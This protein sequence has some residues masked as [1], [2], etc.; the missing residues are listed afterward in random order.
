MVGKA[1][2]TLANFAGSGFG[3]VGGVVATQD[4]REFVDAVLFFFEDVFE[5]DF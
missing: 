1:Y 2:P 4:E 5:E 3:G